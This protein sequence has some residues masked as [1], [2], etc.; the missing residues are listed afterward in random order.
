LQPR[1]A[2]CTPEGWTRITCNETAL[3]ER[4]QQLETQYEAARKELVAARGER[5]Q[6]QHMNGVMEA[7]LVV[8]DELLEAILTCVEVG[9]ASRQHEVPA[10]CFCRPCTHAMRVEGL[11]RLV[12]CKQHVRNEMGVS[13][14]K[15]FSF[16]ATRETWAAC[17]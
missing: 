2:S 5:L 13:S 14:F 8:R 11:G 1:S 6:L 16:R 12:P 9:L 10:L 15:R 7:H 4:A 17:N 3:Q